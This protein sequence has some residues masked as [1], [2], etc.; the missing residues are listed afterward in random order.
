L[1]PFCQ[2]CHQVDCWLGL[3]FSLRDSLPSGAGPEQVDVLAQH[4]RQLGR[5]RGLSGRGVE[6]RT[7]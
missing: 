7:S 5:D 3:P 4:D 6:K 1:R 2:D